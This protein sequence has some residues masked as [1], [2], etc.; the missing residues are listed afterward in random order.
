MAPSPAGE[1]VTGS[2]LAACSPPLLQV[3]TVVVDG[4]LVVLLRGE[5]DLTACEVL[6][7]L[8]AQVAARGLPV[9]IDASRV[10][11]MDCAGLAAVLSLTADGDLASLTGTTRPVQVLLDAA[12]RAEGVVRR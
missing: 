7:P 11:F 8:R 9:V 10:T 1:P 5:V 2:P 3:E 12:A 4:H 6:A